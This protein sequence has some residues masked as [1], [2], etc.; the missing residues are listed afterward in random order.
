MSA[1]S[2]RVPVVPCMSVMPSQHMLCTAG[3]PIA[4][5][6]SKAIMLH[7]GMLTQKRPIKAAVLLCRRLTAAAHARYLKGNTFYTVAQLAGKQACCPGFAHSLTAR[8]ACHAAQSCS[9][10]GRVLATPVCLPRHGAPLSC[11]HVLP[12]S[13]QLRCSLSRLYLSF[14]TS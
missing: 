5:M 6:Y 2:A 9:V 11:L 8:T 10:A 1:G 7:I 14:Q 3:C 13:E 4:S 12:C